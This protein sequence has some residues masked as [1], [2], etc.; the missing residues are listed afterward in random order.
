MLTLLQAIITRWADPYIT[1]LLNGTAFTSTLISLQTINWINPQSVSLGITAI[2]IGL[3]ASWQV[4][5]AQD[6][7]KEV[8]SDLTEAEAR[9][10]RDI[11]AVYKS[12][13]EL[14]EKQR[15]DGAQT[16][17]DIHKHY[18]KQRKEEQEE[19]KRYLEKVE[20]TYKKEIANLANLCKKL[21]TQ[22]SKD[23]KIKQEKRLNEPRKY[24]FLR[25]EA[26][27]KQIQLQA[28]TI[29]DITTP[30]DLLFNEAT[31]TLKKYDK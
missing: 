22:L 6:K 4:G 18:S 25:S 1:Q 3:M 19:A 21:N 2:I 12:S 26:I 16:N 28:D 13:N 17:N 11:E 30:E 23:N 29:L 24:D 20:N 15:R 8:E 31:E 10:K 7:T 14:L 9:A 27:E 5:R